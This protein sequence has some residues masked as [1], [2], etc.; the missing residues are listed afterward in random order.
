MQLNNLSIMT[1]DVDHVDEICQDVIRQQKEGV[2][3]VAMFMMYFAPEG[4][5]TVNKAEIQ[6]KNFDLFRERLDKAGAKYG[7]LVQS[8]MGHISP[9]STPHT[10]QNVVSVLDG[11]KR[12]STCCPLDED[13]K[14]Y[15]KEQMKILA[16]RNPSI[17]MIDDDLGTLYRANLRGCACPLH[18]A[19]FNRKAGTNF[20]REQLY[21][22]MTSGSEEGKRYEQI[23]A[24][25][26]GDSIVDLVKAM[27]EGI[28]EVNP[29]I[30]GA[31]SGI[32]GNYWLEFS[33][34]TAE[35]FAGKNN[36]KMIRL[37]G[38]IYCNDSTKWFSMSK[39]RASHMMH[40]AGRE[41]TVF[42]AETDT[43]PHNRY[44]TSA[45]KLNAHYTSLLLEGAKGAKHWL[46]RSAFESE[47]GKAYRKILSKYSKFHQAVADLYDKLKPVGARIPLFGK[48]DYGFSSKHKGIHPFPW[49]SCV[50][51]R[52]GIPVY[53]SAEQGGA[54]FIDD[55][56]PERLTD[57][58]IAPIFKG[59]VIMTANA[60]N[61]LTEKGYGKHIG[62][63]AQDWCGKS[64]GAEYINGIQ[65]SVQAQSKQLVI[66]DNKVQVLNYAYHTGMG[67]TPE[68]LF[69]A[70]T[71]FENELGGVTFVFCG[72]PDTH[73]NYYD[74]AFSFL[75]QTRKA[76]IIEMMK[77]NGNL[78]VYYPEDCNIYMRAG[79]LND[80]KL[81]VAL[82]N[83]DLDVV[84]NL[85]L[86]FDKPVKSIE[87]LMPDGTRQKVNFTIDGKVTRLDIDQGVYEPIILFAE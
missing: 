37:N 34:E 20:T 55:Y 74:G 72:T 81:M 38:G 21:E 30:Q 40:Y 4:T 31:V 57:E 86:V 58:E 73:F 7:I 83:T 71:R 25:V 64:V 35:A 13:F 23:F 24:R 54:V 75:N 79:Y 43:C 17:I 59:T 1:I 62:V 60:C 76:Q 36:E 52:L 32:L 5:P 22:K 46:T 63:T 3:S 87:R 6:C 78:P 69:P 67:K 19:E 85:P 68:R 26:Q 10:F 50:L 33:N 29:C 49:S 15:L 53:F 84:E 61:L 80:G 2:S 66:N 42:L 56:L 8:T 82:F 48:I 39:A 70:V 9:P 14:K 47:S 51:E 16:T 44:A 28:D 45:S 77:T 18:L 41:N 65:C 12:E 11:A 27:R